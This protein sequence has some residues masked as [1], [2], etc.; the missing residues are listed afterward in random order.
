ME[1]VRER[2]CVV[3]WKRGW[4]G[5]ERLLVYVEKDDVVFLFPSAI[6]VLSLHQDR[7]EREKEQRC[8]N[9]RERGW[10]LDSLQVTVG[11]RQNCETGR[12]VGD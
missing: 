7:L 12:L 8:K 1:N 6:F 2:M 3:R 11:M 4:G 5:G 10:E 9:S